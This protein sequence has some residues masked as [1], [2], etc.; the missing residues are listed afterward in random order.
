MSQPKTR[1]VESVYELR[2]TLRDVK[3]S[4]WRLIRVPG[5]CSLFQLHCILQI[6]MG[7]EDHHMH[8]FQIGDVKYRLPNKD[9]DPDIA[10]DRAVLLADIVSRVGAAFTYLYDFGDCWVH[11]IQVEK[12]MEPES[13]KFYPYCV[14]GQRSCPPEDCGGV[15][16]YEFFLEAIQDPKHPEHESTLLWAE[17]DFN[18]LAFDLKSINQQLRIT[19]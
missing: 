15:T 10:D 19:F 3:P 14:D 17:R 7:W 11:E 18:P 9:A 4:V 16:G 13:E 12:A 1:K 2:V 6:T 8:Q 5:A